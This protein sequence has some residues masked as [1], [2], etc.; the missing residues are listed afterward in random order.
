[1][2]C[3]EISKRSQKIYAA[4]GGELLRYS[5]HFP[6]FSDEDKGIE[7]INEFY[8]TVAEKCEEFCTGELHEYCE[9]K[10]REEKAYRPYSYRLVCSVEREDDECISVLI[11]ASLKRLGESGYVG[12]YSSAHN[13]D[14]RNGILMPPELILKKYA[15]EIK[16]PRK[17]IR[18]NKLSAIRLSEKGVLSLFDGAWKVL[19]L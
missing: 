1:M 5:L 4:D 8:R 17:Y 11:S 2:S 10:R 7:K 16:N 18:Q 6:V 19:S 3:Y 15:P 14:K 13:F 9:A 12:R